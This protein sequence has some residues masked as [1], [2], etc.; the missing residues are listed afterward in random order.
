MH[1]IL[2]AAARNILATQ[3][4]A[5][6]PQLTLGFNTEELSQLEADR[7]HW[8]RRLVQLVR[9]LDEEP[10][11][12]R[13][14]YAVRATRVEPV[15]W[16]TC[17]RWRAEVPMPTDPDELRAH[18]QW[19]GYLQPVGLVVAAAALGQA[20]GALHTD[21]RRGPA[22]QPV[23]GEAAVAAARG[24]RSCQELADSLVE[25]ARLAGR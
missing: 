25:R 5:A 22:R 4:E 14:G 23:L 1:E 15:G 24:A 17:G 13:D 10:A 3:R 8:D 19:L 20:P 16:C 9:E 21:S 2:L 7:R 6:S 12:I 18:Q 11:R